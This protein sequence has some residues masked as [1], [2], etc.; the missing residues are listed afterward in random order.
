[1]TNKL[2]ATHRIKYFWKQAFDEFGV[3]GNNFNEWY[4]V[5]HPEIVDIELRIFHGDTPYNY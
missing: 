5:R 4:Q 2:R 1:M 3:C